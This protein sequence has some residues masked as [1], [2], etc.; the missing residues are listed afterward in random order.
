VP[1][2]NGFV[3]VGI[4]GVAEKLKSRGDDIKRHWRALVDD[5]MQSGHLDADPGEPGGYS[6]FLRPRAT[7]PQLGNAFVVGDAAGLATRDMCEGI[8]P[9][10]QSGLMAAATILGRDTFDLDRIEAHTLGQ[11]LARRAL[12]YVLTRR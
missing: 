6:Y 1:K 10:V 4:G 9:A 7:E 2:E 12:D 11:P 3:N 8:G 5:L